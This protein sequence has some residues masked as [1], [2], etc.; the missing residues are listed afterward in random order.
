MSR[1]MSNFSVPE[2]TRILKQVVPLLDGLFNVS[3]VSN[4]KDLQITDEVS[5]SISDT[6]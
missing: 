3:V 2:R 5:D 4:V 1:N 6:M